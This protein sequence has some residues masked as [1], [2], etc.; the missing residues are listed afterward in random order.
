MA[1]ARGLMG[2]HAAVGPAPLLSKPEQMIDGHRHLTTGLGQR[3]AVLHG[4]EFGETLGEGEIYDSN[5]YTL[6][7]MLTECG[8][9]IIDLGVV[10]DNPDALREAFSEAA[11]SG[12]R[13]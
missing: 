6:Y 9:D 7:A 12:L 5:R 8:A 10:R 1:L 4:D 2:H 11:L 13:R 3:L